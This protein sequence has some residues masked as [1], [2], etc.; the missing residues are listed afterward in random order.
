MLYS[1]LGISNHDHRVFYG[2]QFHFNFDIEIN[3]FIFCSLNY[4]K[5]N[6]VVGRDVITCVTVLVY[7]GEGKK[8]GI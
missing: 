6:F 4:Y 8:T 1:C 2:I 7:V 5:S 3:N